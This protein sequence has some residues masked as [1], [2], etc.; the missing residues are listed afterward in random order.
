[1][2]VCSTL[3]CPYTVAHLRWPAASK[4]VWAIWDGLD[5]RLL[6]L[7]SRRHPNQMQDFPLVFPGYWGGRQFFHFPPIICVW[8]N[9]RNQGMRSFG[10]PASVEAGKA[11]L[12]LCVSVMTQLR[13]SVC[14]VFS[15]VQR[16][17]N[18]LQS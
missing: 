17:A 13:F 9:G 11:H 18:W 12:Q 8:K 3:Q 10:G 7:F 15:C 1:M 5:G 16:S 4:V 2:L 14:G 6:G